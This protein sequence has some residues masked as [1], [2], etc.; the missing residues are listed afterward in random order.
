MFKNLVFS[1]F[2][3]QKSDGQKIAIIGL[4]TTLNFIA[5]SFL[6]FKTFDVQFSFTILFACLT[7]IIIGGV[8]GF[9]SCFIADLLGYILNSWGYVYMPWVA[10]STGTFALISGFLFSKNSKKLVLKI[11][12]LIV[13]SFSI[14]TIFINS[15]GFYFYNKYMGFSTAVLNY[16]SNLF[17]SDKV[18]Y[19]GYLLYRLIFKLQILNSAFNYVLFVASLPILKRLKVLN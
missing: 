11:I 1:K 7:G 3:S 5:N 17:G 18:G 14:C 2:I 19:I 15:T 10:L 16:V 9:F 13:L 6:E 8:S 4:I 12:L